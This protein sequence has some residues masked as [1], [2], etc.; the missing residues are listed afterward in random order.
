MAGSAFDGTYC[1]RPDLV[2]VEGFLS[3]WSRAWRELTNSSRDNLPA[4]AAPAALRLS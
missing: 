3:P 4:T 1:L 2:R